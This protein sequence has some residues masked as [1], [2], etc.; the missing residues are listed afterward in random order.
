MT[1]KLPE[2]LRE[3]ANRSATEPSNKKTLE[4]VSW[5]EGL[6]GKTAEERARLIRERILG[7]SKDPLEESPKR[8]DP[9]R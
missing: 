9:A 4:V 1:F 2:S 6:V 8:L 3:W 7:K 5:A